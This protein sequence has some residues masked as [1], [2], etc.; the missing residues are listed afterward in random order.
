MSIHNIKSTFEKDV[1]SFVALKFPESEHQ[2]ELSV[3]LL[4]SITINIPNWK[5]SRKLSGW[6]HGLV[7][8]V[9]AEELEKGKSQIGGPLYDARADLSI[10]IKPIIDLTPENYHQALIF[11]EIEGKT[12]KQISTELH[13]SLTVVKGILHNGRT[14]MKHILLQ[15]F[16]DVKK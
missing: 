5:E 11:S 16:F 7:A 1:T 2:R 4:D 3:K 12:Q 9:I 13:T 6:I 15:C 8:E 14:M 10:M